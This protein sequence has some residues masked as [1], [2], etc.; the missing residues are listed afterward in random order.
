MKTVRTPRTPAVKRHENARG[1]IAVA[2]RSANGA[3]ERG[4]R[5]NLEIAVIIRIPA[6][7]YVLVEIL[8]IQSFLFFFKYKPKKYYF[9]I[10]I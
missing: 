6:E 3:T 5:E 9:C 1:V 10:N 7:A 8:D 2:T 4:G